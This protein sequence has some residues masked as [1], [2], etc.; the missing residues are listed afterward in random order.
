MHSVESLFDFVDTKTLVLLFLIKLLSVSEM[1]LI[2]KAKASLS[3]L[4]IQ[5]PIEEFE[6]HKDRI[7]I[8]ILESFRKS[9]QANGF[10][11]QFQKICS[12]KWIQI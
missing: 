4:K 1:N 8:S 3:V 11:S 10:E 5:H 9:A 7:Q 2:S 6:S 12:D